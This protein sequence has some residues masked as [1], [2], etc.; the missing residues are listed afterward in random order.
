ME[1]PI[2]LLIFFK[3]IRKEKEKSCASGYLDDECMEHMPR[4]CFRCVYEDNIITKYQNPPKDNKKQRKQIYCSERG[5]HASNKECDKVENRNY[6]NIYVSMAH[7]S[8]NDEY[9]GRH[10]G[11]SLQL[12]NWICIQE[13]R[14]EVG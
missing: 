12:T 4:K 8:D 10:F 1:V 2:I 14:N 13:Q 5:K 7:M 9:P 11:D 3:I 6:Q